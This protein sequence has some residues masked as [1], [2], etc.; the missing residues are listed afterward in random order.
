MASTFW[1]ELL[2]ACFR[3]YAH[4]QQ[5]PIDPCVYFRVS[6][7]G[8]LILILCFHGDDL[9]CAGAA[10][11]RAALEKAFAQAGLKYTGG[12]LHQFLATDYVVDKDM[13]IIISNIHYVSSKIV[14]A[15]EYKT[16][17][18]KRKCRVP[19]KLKRV[20]Q[21]VDIA[22]LTKDMGNKERADVYARLMLRLPS[23]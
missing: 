17:V 14:S 13:N 6:K 18:G 15:E 3:D 9:L 19:A 7:H 22:E 5:H 2:Q 1:G 10:A 21:Y 4:L 11:A 23:A 12:E 20:H 16:R 8:N